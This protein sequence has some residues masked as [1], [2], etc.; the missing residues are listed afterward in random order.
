MLEEWQYSAEILI[1]HFRCVLRG[2]LPFSQNT[3]EAHRSYARAS[4]DP[5]AVEYMRK[6]SAIIEAR[7]RSLFYR[8]RLLRKLT[9]YLL[10]RR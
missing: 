10:F 7:S 1:A 9:D 5:E 8:A 2:H 6:V 3:T 4:L